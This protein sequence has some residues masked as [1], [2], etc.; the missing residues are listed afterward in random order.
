MSIKKAVLF[1]PWML[2]PAGG[3]FTAADQP[4]FGGEIDSLIIFASGENAL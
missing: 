2:G 4:I 3:R 1:I